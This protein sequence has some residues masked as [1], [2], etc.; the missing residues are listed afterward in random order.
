VIIKKDNVR[1]AEAPRQIG[2]AAPT[3]PSPAPSAA[4]PATQPAAQLVQQNDSGAQIEV[5]CA[6]GRRIRVQC[7]YAMGPGDA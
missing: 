1:M 7:D 6:C 5:T 3:A 2:A 4:A